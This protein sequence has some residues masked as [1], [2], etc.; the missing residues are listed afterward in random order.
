MF[1]YLQIRWW[2]TGDQPQIYLVL[3]RSELIEPWLRFIAPWNFV[4]NDADRG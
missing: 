4:T 2:S 1:G 3:H